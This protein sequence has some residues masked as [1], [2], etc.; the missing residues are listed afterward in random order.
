MCAA[1]R[2]VMLVDDDVDYREAVSAVLEQAGYTVVAAGSGLEALRL[3]ESSAVSPDLI[4]LDLAQPIMD[5]RQFVREHRSRP[6]LAGIPVALISGEQDLGR[7]AAALAVDDYLLKPVGA[8][9]LLAL[10]RRLAGL[11]DRSA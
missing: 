7:Q 5:G 2:L 3:L 8:D 1:R 6:A 10:V 11:P 4:L 9:A